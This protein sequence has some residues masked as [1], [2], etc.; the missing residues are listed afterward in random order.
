M[1]IQEAITRADEKRPNMV[2]MSEK[3]RAL[4]EIDGLIHAEILMK[5]AHTAAEETPPAYD[6]ATDP[7]TDLLIPAPYDKL[8]IDWLCCE[9]D[10]RNQEM[11]KYNNDRSM[12][13]NHYQLM[14]D[15]VNRSRMP[16]GAVREVMI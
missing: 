16:I 4:N 8:Y 13:E 11:D 6:D 7:A 10:D 12:F 9:I 15:W 14:A 2:L 1:T 3:V 5:H